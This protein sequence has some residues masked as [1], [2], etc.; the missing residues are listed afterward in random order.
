MICRSSYMFTLP[1]MNVSRMCCYH[2]LSNEPTLVETFH[3]N[4]IK[5][6]SLQ[7]LDM[8]NYLLSLYV[9]SLNL[10]YAHN[11][12]DQIP[13]RDVRS[14]S[15][16]LSGY[17]RKQSFPNVF[18]VFRNM[19]IQRLPP[20]H[21]TL[22]TI[23]KC[24]STL[25]DLRLGKEVHG[26]IVRNGIDLDNA[27]ENSLLDFYA[28]CMRLEHAKRVFESMEQK[29]CLSWNIMLAAYLRNR[30]VANSLSLFKSLSRKDVAT[31]NTLI[32]GLRKI[33]SLQ[34]AMDM[35]R[36][37]TESGSLFNKVTFSISLNLASSLRDLQ[38]GKQIHCRVLRFDVHNDNFIRN[39]LID[40][41]GKCE[42]MEKAS[43]VFSRTSRD[44]VFDD[45]KADIVSRSSLITGFIQNGDFEN[46]L[47]KY[48][49]MFREG[50]KVDKF[51]LT[52]I[53]S[54]CANSGNLGIGQQIHSQIQKTGHHF[55]PYLA[56]SLISM[57]AKCGNLNE[58]QE[59]F[60]Q[61]KS[62][63]IAMWTSMIS[64]YASHGQGTE[65]V[66]LFESMINKGIQPNEITFIVVLTACCHSG[67]VEQGR[68]YFMIM[69]EIYDITPEIEHLNCMVDLFGR[70][71]FLHEAKAFIHEH[72]ISHLSAVWKS[73]LSSCRL[74]Y[75]V[76]MEKWA[77]EKLLQ[78]EPSD[79]APYI[80]SASI[81]A[82]DH[83]WEDAANM[84]SLM[85]DRKDRDLGT[86]EIKTSKL[87]GYMVMA[88]EKNIPW[89][90][91]K[92][93]LK[94]GIYVEKV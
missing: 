36:Q 66:R 77:L 29:C 15:I 22:S 20:N 68:K 58:A 10:V 11:L 86:Q 43:I 2:S 27:L 88:K 26:W 41:Y 18:H 84:R 23:F 21:F 61:T 32:D 54:A 4:Q 53:I 13:E 59:I 16:L 65:A 55:D 64:G 44:F 52:S 6:G 12:F 28:K 19:Q 92:R 62:S 73:F 39:S 34:I 9:K 7:N 25:R 40:M 76:E 69:K 70:A 72:G 3:A 24:C 48:I 78:M 74:H 42:K 14:W 37:M 33:G 87:D 82:S 17:A 31:W 89:K 93:R 81:L 75:N 79:A 91:L 49:T 51:T 57:Y 63:N 50:F 83:K 30:D 80:L 71:G 1:W 94:I 46:A 47:E 56:S 35:L 5:D 67:L 45:E 38:L 85:K 8:G 60:I 90:R